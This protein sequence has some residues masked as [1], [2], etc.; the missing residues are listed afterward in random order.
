MAEQHQWSDPP[1]HTLTVEI[2][3]QKISPK[4]LTIGLAT[5]TLAH[6]CRMGGTSKPANHPARSTLD[7]RNRPPVRHRSCHST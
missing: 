5:D 2:T 4:W 7:H 3:H 1:R 6:H